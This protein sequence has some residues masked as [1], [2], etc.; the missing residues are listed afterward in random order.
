MASMSERCPPWVKE[1]GSFNA[2][3]LDGVDGGGAPRRNDA[4]NGGRNAPALPMATAI[5][6]R[7]TLVIS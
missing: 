5:T 6:G 4:G 3:G 1:R 2:Q 7:L